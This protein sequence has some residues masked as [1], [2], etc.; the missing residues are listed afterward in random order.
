MMYEDLN[1]HGFVVVKN[2]LNALELKY[3][4]QAHA[5]SLPGP[6]I[7]T[8]S[9]KFQNAADSVV[10]TFVPKIKQ[11]ILKDC[12]IDADVIIPGGTFFDTTKMDLS[13]HQDHGTF[14]FFREHVNLL[15]YYIPFIKPD[16]TLSGLSLISFEQL[17][18]HDPKGHARLVNAGANSFSPEGDITRVS[19]DVQG[20]EWQLKVNL[21]DI[22]VSP[23][24][25]PG[26]LVLMRGDCI[27]RTQDNKTARVSLVMHS[28]K[29]ST[30]IKSSYTEP[31]TEALRRIFDS[32]ADTVS[33]IKDKFKRIGK[34]DVDIYE[35]YAADLARP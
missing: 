28:I 33:M 26:D 1:T 30:R 21:D 3:L 27:H 32:N 34:D 18:K 22:S 25:E 29:G 24:L 11:K 31:H 10:N 19:D 9:Y 16:P 5:N 20:T 12:C 2:F 7:S 17:R 13:W 8:G 23:E 35:W 15:K 6:H 4:R 14:L